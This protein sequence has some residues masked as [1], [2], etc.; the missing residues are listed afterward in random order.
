MTQLQGW[1][2]IALLAIGGG[3]YASGSAIIL[4]QGT[5]SKSKT[6]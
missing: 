4:K 3:M 5:R 6:H 2:I 1:I